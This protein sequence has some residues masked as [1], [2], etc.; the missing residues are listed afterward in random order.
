M[1]NQK[2][3]TTGL[4]KHTPH[5]Q[6][7][8]KIQEKKEKRDRAWMEERVARQIARAVE[9]KELKK[10]E[11]EYPEEFYKMVFLREFEHRRRCDDMCFS[12]EEL[13]QCSNAEIEAF[14]EVVFLNVRKIWKEDLS[15]AI[16]VPIFGWAFGIGFFIAYFL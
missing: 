7:F 4:V 3:K 2:E 9:E 14:E 5:E 8:L 13:S 12:L 6:I 1:A 16:F 10:L 15:A 11:G